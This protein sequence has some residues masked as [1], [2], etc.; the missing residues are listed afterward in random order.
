MSRVSFLSN[1]T[2]K[3]EL[4]LVFSGG[5]RLCLHNHVYESWGRFFVNLDINNQLQEKK[6]GSCFQ[7]FAEFLV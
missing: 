5:C 4:V 1:N 2:T 6:L 7:K 3:D